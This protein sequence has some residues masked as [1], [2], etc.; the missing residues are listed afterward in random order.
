[1]AKKRCFIT[2]SVVAGKD[3]GLDL[4]TTKK[5]MKRQKDD[6]VIIYRLLLASP[7][8]FQA[9]SL[10]QKLLKHAKKSPFLFA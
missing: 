1:M 8:L 9:L 10:D 2:R 4:H 3:E 6:Y 7:S 5:P